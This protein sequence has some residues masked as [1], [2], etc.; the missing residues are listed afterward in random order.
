M[1]KNHPK[2]KLERVSPEA[3]SVNLEDLKPRGSKPQVSFSG[4]RLEKLRPERVREVLEQMRRDEGV[5]GYL[6]RNSR[7]ASADLIDPTKLVDYAILSSSTKETS[8]EFS[9]AFDL[10]GIENVLI[11]GKD[12]KLLFQNVGDNDVNIFMEKFVEHAKISKTL[13]SLT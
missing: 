1:S 6:L 3:V 8:E 9:Q 2:G 13:C 10:G 5:V 7:A 11:E 4:N 12:L